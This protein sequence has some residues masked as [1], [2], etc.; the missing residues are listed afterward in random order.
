MNDIERKAENYARG[1]V[2]PFDDVPSLGAVEGLIEAAFLAGAKDGT[3]SI[4]ELRAAFAAG[5]KWGE[6][7]NHL[8][9]PKETYLQ[10]KS[11]G[12]AEYLTKREKGE[13]K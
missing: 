9:Y 7:E 11:S 4:D 13:T 5:V 8:R 2:E 6:G 10:Y 12:F 3:P 1:V